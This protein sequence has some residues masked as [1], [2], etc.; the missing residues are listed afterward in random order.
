MNMMKGGILQLI[1]RLDKIHIVYLNIW[2]LFAKFKVSLP[3]FRSSHH[4]L[5]IERARHRTIPRNERLC[6]NYNTV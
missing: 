1:T 3:K 4:D 2:K 6:R 5:A